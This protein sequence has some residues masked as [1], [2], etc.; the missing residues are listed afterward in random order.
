MP[1]FPADPTLVFAAV[2]SL[3]MIGA[4]LTGFRVPPRRAAVAAV[5]VL[6]FFAWY[7][8]TAIYTVS[9]G[10]WERKALGLTLDLLAFIVPI[11]CF[12]RKEHFALFEWAT[13]IFALI[14]TAIVLS[15]YSA[16]LLD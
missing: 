11:I 3:A 7:Y 6:A 14:A 9:S 15:L 1:I 4:S 8:F 2:L 13:A 16:G 10:F 12:T 5:L